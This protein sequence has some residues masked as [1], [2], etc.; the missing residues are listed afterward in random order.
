[1][2]SESASRLATCLLLR[3]RPEA[4]K[5]PCP[6][7]P[8]R[9]SQVLQPS[10]SHQVTNPPDV[11][12]LSSA[13]AALAAAAQAHGRARLLPAAL[14]AVAVRAVARHVAWPLAPPA[15]AVGAVARVVAVLGA[16]KAGALP[17]LCRAVACKVA[18]AAALEA[19][20][21]C[22]L[23]VFI[24]VP[25]GPQQ[26]MQ[27]SI[28]LLRIL[29]KNHACGRFQGC[30]P[31]IVGIAAAAAASA[32]AVLIAADLT[33]A[34]HVSI[35]VRLAVAAA[36]APKWAGA[37]CSVVQAAFRPLS[38]LASYTRALMCSKPAV[39]RVLHALCA[40]QHFA[41][42]GGRRLWAAGWRQR[43][44]TG[45][46]GVVSSRPAPQRGVQWMAAAIITRP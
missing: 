31:G 15:Q 13:G 27:L 8:S 2:H 17:S 11:V 19:A 35:Q 37:A 45:S 30:W 20:Q 3:A 42:L 28:S 22:L 40:A 14:L 33:C 41:A 10:Q 34:S 29:H 24:K 9:T 16:E 6:T 25:G 1:M 23:K 44:A 46:V 7:F 21:P 18:L 4:L 39:L 36:A 43:S 32:A 38:F 26:A 5:S 12:L